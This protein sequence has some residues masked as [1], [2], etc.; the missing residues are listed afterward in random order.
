MKGLYSNI[1]AKRECIKAGQA[2]R[3]ITMEGILCA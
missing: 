3:L 2:A 1:H